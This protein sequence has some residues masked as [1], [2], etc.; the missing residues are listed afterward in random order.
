LNELKNISIKIPLLQA[1]KDIPIYAK[2]IKELCNKKTGRKKQ[3]PQTIQVVGKLASLMTTK[4]ISE[5]YVDPGILI[6]TIFVNKFSI[7][8][9]L[10][11]LGA[12]INVMT[13]ETMQN[14]HIGN[15]RPTPMVLELA[16]RSKIKPEGVIEDIIVS[17][18]SWEYPVDFMILQPKSNL[19]GH[20]LILGDH[21]WQQLMHSSVVDQKYD[22]HKWC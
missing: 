7:P 4:V 19:G 12:T 14:L 13:M 16:D 18:D 22:N 17:L 2:T 5:K 11:D 21:G 9:T 20:P 15:L 6:V 3:D 1:I 10:I 8:N